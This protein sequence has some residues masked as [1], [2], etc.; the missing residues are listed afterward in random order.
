MKLAFKKIARLRDK[1]Q[2]W[3]S[4]GWKSFREFTFRSFNLFHHY[5]ARTDYGN[6]LVD[7]CK[8]ALNTRNNTLLF[9]IMIKLDGITAS[10]KHFGFIPPSFNLKSFKDT[11]ILPFTKAFYEGIM[12]YYSHAEENRQ[13]EE[14]IIRRKFSAFKESR[15]PWEREYVDTIRTV[16]QSVE[17]GHLGIY[18]NDNAKVYQQIIQ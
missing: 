12:D 4:K 3:R 8:Y 6:R 13:F 5:Q 9:S 15:F 2:F 16:I 18:V 1:A 14:W 7:L 17:A 11:S 10:E